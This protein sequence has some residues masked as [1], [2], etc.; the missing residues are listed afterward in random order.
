[1]CGSQMANAQVAGMTFG[2]R[3]GTAR[4]ADSSGG[5]SFSASRSVVTRFE[6][7]CSPR[8]RG[9]SGADQDELFQGGGGIGHGWTRVHSDAGRV[10]GGDRR[11]V[12][13]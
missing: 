9:V 2:L 4:S 7:A 6:K 10:G 1:M 8:G 11:I 12:M 13:L 5:R 3:E